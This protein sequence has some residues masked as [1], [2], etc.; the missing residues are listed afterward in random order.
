MK[1]QLC[2]H[3]ALG[4]ALLSLIGLASGCDRNAQSQDGIGSGSGGSTPSAGGNDTA[5]GSGGIGT[6]DSSTGGSSHILLPPT[7]PEYHPPLGFDDCIHAKVRED[8]DGGWCKLPSGCFVI[9]APEDEWR[10]GR[11]TDEQVAITFTHPVE[12]QQ[13]EMSRAE[14][15]TITSVLPTGY[16][17]EDDGECLEED[18][19]I[20][21]VTWWEAVHA[22]NLLSEQRGLDPCYAPVNCTS[23]LGQGLACEAVAEPEKSVYDCEGYRLPTRS[24]AEYAARAGTISTWYSGN[25]TVYDSLSCNFD[26]N[27]DKIG[28]YCF[29]SKNRAHARGQKLRNGF[30]LFDMIG[31]AGEWTNEEDRYEA[32]AGGEDPK[33]EVGQLRD[34]LIF[35]GAY[36]LRS[37]TCRSASI[38]AA[39]WEGRGYR[40]GFRLYR[41]LFEDSERSKAIVK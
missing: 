10:R 39:Y 32:A 38:F 7:G 11:Y 40:T 8:C 12:A 13:M 34:R 41:T 17:Q 9:G 24:E 29:N 27:L 3:G 16:K 28:W 6:A 31:N 35:G 23:E 18:C 15:Q 26:E 22:A 14:W 4:V 5:Q 37:S 33:G 19:P 25:I 20:N 21:N 36:N 2:Q 30:G 1:K